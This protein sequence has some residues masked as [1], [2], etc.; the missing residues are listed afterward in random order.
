MHSFDRL[1]VISVC[2]VWIQHPTSPERKQHTS[3]ELPSCPHGPPSGSPLDGGSRWLCRLIIPIFSDH[4]HNSQLSETEVS[5]KVQFVQFHYRVK[6]LVCVR[7]PVC[8]YTLGHELI[9]HPLYNRFVHCHVKSTD[10]NLIVGL[11]R[12]LG[13][14]KSFEFMLWGP[15]MSLQW[16]TQ[17]LFG[18]SLDQSGRLTKCC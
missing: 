16:S 5:Q 2:H 4:T 10:V 8:L 1:A 11:E 18:F 12:K 17:Q 3:L 7:R 9:N 6:L 14:P 15:W 13:P